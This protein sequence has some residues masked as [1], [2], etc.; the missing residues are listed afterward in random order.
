VIDTL[1]L[2]H[3]QLTEKEL[4][5]LSDPAEP[6][7]LWIAGTP[8]LTDTWQA[9]SENFSGASRQWVG[10]GFTPLQF[11]AKFND[12][13][14]LGPLGNQIIAGKVKMIDGEVGW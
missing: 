1:T 7:L 2:M 3:E 11:R 14:H 4:S 6:Q 5:F 9:A 13:V 8:A 10:P 12:T